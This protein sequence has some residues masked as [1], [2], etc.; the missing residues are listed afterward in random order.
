MLLWISVVASCFD[1]DVIAHPA[2]APAAPAAELTSP[3]WPAALVWEV[4]VTG[5]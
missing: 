5:P 4:V 3:A 1:S 2:N